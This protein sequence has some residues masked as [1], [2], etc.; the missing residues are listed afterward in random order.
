MKRYAINI[1][2]TKQYFVLTDNLNPIDEI[3]ASVVVAKDETINNL[4]EALIDEAKLL[5]G[6]DVSPTDIKCWVE[7]G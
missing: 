6:V 3:L 5:N 1:D 2:T 4:T 7:L